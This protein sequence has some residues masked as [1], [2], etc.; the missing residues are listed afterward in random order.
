MRLK[1][2]PWAL[3][4]KRSPDDHRGFL[5]PVMGVEDGWSELRGKWE[6]S[7][8]RLQGERTFKT[9]CGVRREEER[10][11]KLQETHR[12]EGRYF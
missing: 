3:A 7:I 6:G 8:W 5:K 2:Y 1:N 12:V 10:G 4:V 11:L 9:L